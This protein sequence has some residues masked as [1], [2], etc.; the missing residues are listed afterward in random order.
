MTI[1]SDSRLERILH[2]GTFAV[3]AEVVPPLGGDPTEVGEQA[4]GLAGFADAVNVTDSPTS[5]AH[6][7]PVAGAALVAREGIEPVL[8][9]A[10]R[11][12]NRLALTG[13]LLGGWALGARNLLCLTGDPVAA[14][15]HPDAIEVH[16]LSVVE[17]VGLAVRL[18]DRGVSLAGK[19]VEPPP[20]YF[21]GV[22]D[23]PFAADYDPA[24]LEEKADAGADF[25]QTQ[26]TYDVDALG[27]W[28]DVVR[29]RGLFE[30]MFVLIGVAPPR[31]TASAVFMR[32]HLPGVVVPDK[33]LRRLE[34]ADDPVH[35]GVGLTVEVVNGLRKIPGIA[36]VHVMGL[37]REDGVR[38]VIEEAGLLPRP[39]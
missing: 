13:D 24:K 38:R 1:R 4:R 22:A 26:I 33:I 12:R 21:V 11:D 25:V 2:D 37:G 30:R 7:S 35:E 5:S 8:Q 28:A 29:A 27:D 19:P 32:Q 9:L 10:C 17:L 36:G 6:M 16:D 20:R 15:D 14:G 3:T 23:V 34:Q 18:R 31:S 39:S